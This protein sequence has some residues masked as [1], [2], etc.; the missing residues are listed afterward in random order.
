[1][2]MYMMVGFMY[3]YIMFGIFVLLLI[4]NSFYYHLGKKIKIKKL[5]KLEQGKGKG[6]KKQ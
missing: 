1:M 3:K 5:F 6:K 2:C 4:F